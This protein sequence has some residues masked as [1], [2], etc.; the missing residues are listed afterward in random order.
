MKQ[1]P[2]CQEDFADKFGFCPVDGTP[3]NWDA[4]VAAAS[5][6]PPQA[7]DESAAYA[8]AASSS[9]SQAVDGSFDED[10]T[11]FSGS[12]VEREE[13]HLT[14]LEDEGLT[15]RL[16]RELKSVAH[17]SQLTWPEFKKDPVGFTQRS[18]TAYSRAGWKFF[19]Q[20]NV[21]LAVMVA[22][23]FM[24]GGLTLLFVLDRLQSRNTASATGVNEDLELVQMIDTEIPKE[25]EKPDDGTAGMAKGNG[26][27]SK[28]KQ[29]KAQG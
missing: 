28:P 27:G 6:V 23:I 15:R 17:D 5:D 16:T 26:G 14:F 19:S 21:A 1:C 12:P 9:A 10:E 24:V 18:A 25:Q 13:F 4:D 29:E 3:L 2:T 11:V 22:F 7:S 20:R 8:A